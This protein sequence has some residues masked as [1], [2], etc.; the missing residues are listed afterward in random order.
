MG[1]LAV[2]ASRETLSRSVQSSCVTLVPDPASVMTNSSGS[3]V[4][5]AATVQ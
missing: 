2:S 1:R 5:A 3:S 4:M